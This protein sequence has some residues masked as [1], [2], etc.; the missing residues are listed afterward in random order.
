MVAKLCTS[1]G[2]PLRGQQSC[3][4]PRNAWINAPLKLREGV[5]GSKDT[6]SHTLSRLGAGW[7]LGVVILV[8]FSLLRCNIKRFKTFKTFKFS[9]NYFL[10]EYGHPRARSPRRG[11]SKG[12]ASCVLHLCGKQSTLLLFSQVF[13]LVW[14]VTGAVLMNIWGCQLPVEGWRE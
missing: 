10:P 3:L 11:E 12:C 13:L 4:H 2:I 14:K 6:L 5:A 1:V 8:F 9:S 7:A